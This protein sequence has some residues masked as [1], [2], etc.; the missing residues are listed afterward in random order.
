MVDYKAKS[1]GKMA[2]RSWAGTLVG[3]EAKNQWRI[4]D[5]TRVFIRRDVIFNESKFRHK[6]VTC[7]EPVGENTTDLVTLA[8]M[9]QPVGEGHRI[10]S[11]RHNDPVEPRHPNTPE[12]QHNNSPLPDENSS[13]SQ[14][15]HSI[16]PT[17]EQNTSHPTQHI[18]EDTPDLVNQLLR[19]NQKVAKAEQT[20]P[21]PLSEADSDEQNPLIIN[22]PRHKVR[23]DY[24]QL[25]TRGF[26]KAAI[27]VKPHNIVT[28]NTY[29][30]AMAG[31]QAKEWYAA[32]KSEY[33]CQ[34]ARGTFA[35]T[36]LPYDC[37]AIEGKWVFR[38]KENPDG[39]IERYKAR[40]V[41]KGYRQVEGRDY[42]ET[43]A[44]VVRSD[45]SRILLAISAKLGWKIKQY[46]I[47]TAFLYG[48]M[49][50]RLYTIQPQGFE[51]GNGLVC[52]LN[53]A[54]YGLVQSAYL[55]F[56]ELK[57][58]L[59]DFGLTQSK[60]D[61]ALFY[62]TSRSLY[63]TVYVDDI[64]VFCPDDATILLLKE[65]LQSKYKLKDI[66][67]VT[68]YL[69]M[70]ISRLKD[71]SLLLSQKKYI[72]DLLIRHGMENCA[73]VTTPMQDLK[74]SKTSGE[75][76]CDPKTQADYRKLLGELMYLMVQTRPDLAYSVSKLAQF[77]SNP[78]EEHWTALKR[79]LRYLQ[80]T[81][82]LGICYSKTE[83]EL[84]LSAWTDASWGE[85]PD[86][87]RSTNGY[88]ILMQGGPVAWKS[89]KQ[90]SVALSSTEAEYVGQTMAATTV[91]W[92]RNLLHELQIRGTAPK[93]A[94]II[95][96]DNQGA[97]KLAENP[98]FQKRS[99]HIAVKYHYTR[100]LIQ[101]GEIT[102][103]YKKTQEMIADG[104][105]KP[106]G[107]IAF[108]EFVKCLGLTTEA[109][110]VAAKE[111]EQK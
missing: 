15:E 33:E 56:G 76:T 38:L 31:P 29:K 34:V 47:D 4:W 10:G 17:P 50:R 100:D 103:Q 54:L 46:D 21:P 81:R 102:L 83:G 107:P 74:L 90:Q 11:I 72:R 8:G 96:A 6:N 45:T 98:I 110:A 48:P 82:E 24:K 108:K 22:E 91:M 57:G 62:N 105:T 16:Q 14:N 65:H 63:I 64:K 104:L 44:P 39:S 42:E 109:E 61:D 80:G 67:D 43:Y 73:S 26:A 88:V 71:G 86:D 2:P 93:N 70:E 59:K 19:E 89:Q 55:W 28:P 53:M 9:L 77:M 78:R 101:S 79:V 69:G 5:G 23:H 58:T 18:F 84:T 49:D 12:P 97:I 27:F 20:N 35:I 41:A 37:K 7:S 75:H 51:Q 36:P 111:A 40:W 99:K 13:D 95:Y 66:G 52:L 1:K 87:S 106:L 92:S 94:T 25:H 68:W 30:E 85:D 60:H 32:C 3:Y